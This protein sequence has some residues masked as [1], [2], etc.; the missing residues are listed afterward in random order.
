VRSSFRATSRSR[1]GSPQTKAPPY[2]RSPCG[3]RSTTV[4]IRESRNGGGI[5]GVGLG[6]VGAGA[7]VGVGVG[8]SSEPHPVASAQI[9]TVV[10]STPPAIPRR[11]TFVRALVR[12]LGT[13]LGNF[14]GRQA[15]SPTPGG[16]G[17]F[18]PLR[19]PP[20]TRAT[21]S[22]IVRLMRYSRLSKRFR[23]ADR[24]DENKEGASRSRS[25]ERR[26]L[27]TCLE[28]DRQTLTWRAGSGFS[29]R[30]RLVRT[31]D[32]VIIGTRAPTH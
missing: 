9:T 3:V 2:G 30:P 1:R 25:Q 15:E 19:T 7:G 18:S 11:V 23:S 17:S 10:G 20:R 14:R 5:G 27:G 22:A 21:S 31:I 28:G 12:V 6:A 16:V 26:R 24:T 4:P 8:L 13:I 29:C 32:A